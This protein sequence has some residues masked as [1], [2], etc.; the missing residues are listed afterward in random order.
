MLRLA[1]II[2]FL[3]IFSSCDQSLEKVHVGTTPFFGEAA[4]YVAEAQGFF[5][6]HGLDVISHSHSAGKKS[7]QKLYREEIDIAH[8][9]ELPIV[10]AIQNSEKYEGDIR[11][12]I[13]ANMI[14]NSDM[15][16]IIARRDKGIESPSD[17]ANKKIGYFEG[18]TSEFFLDTFLLEHSVSDNTI[19]NLNIDVAKQLNALRSGKV[20]AVVSWEPHASKILSEMDKNAFELET[21]I[22]HSTLWLVVA[23]NTYITENPDLIK[24]YLQALHQAQAWIKNHPDPTQNLLAQKTNTSKEIIAKLWHTIDYDLSLSERMLLLL[25][26]Q[27][28]WLRQKQYIKHHKEKV[29]F[30]DMVYFKAMEEVYP[31]G[32]TIIR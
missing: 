15:Q 14:Y 32:I 12:K 26:D 6:D 30:E 11:P 9:A 4:F 31:E 5:K 2:S 28:R 25:E 19:E 20:D 3:L 23:S 13:F 1:V 29:N 16:K 21:K 27:Q 17:L 24:A 10:Y 22:D 7:L 18:T 8:T